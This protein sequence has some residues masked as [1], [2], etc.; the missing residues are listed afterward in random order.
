MQVAEF[1]LLFR[2]GVKGAFETSVTEWVKIAHIGR[3]LSPGTF[4]DIQCAEIDCSYCAK[5][6]WLYSTT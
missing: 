1:F 2:L 4:F 3:F 6:D 5:Y